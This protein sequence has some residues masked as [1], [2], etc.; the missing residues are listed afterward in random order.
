MTD[1]NKYTSTLKRNQETVQKNLD[2]LIDEFDGIP[3]GNGYIDIIILRER[4]VDFINRLTELHLAIE[5]ISWWC[6]ATDENIGKFGCPHGFGGP[7]TQFGWFS[8]M[9][10]YH[11]IDKDAI[12]HLENEYTSES[13][14]RINEMAAKMIMDNLA[15]QKRICLTPGFWIRVP[16]DWIRE[17]KE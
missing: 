11:D 1:G 14:R 2:R 8:E 9:C 10:E 5:C 13:V 4:Y 7:M 16:D 17:T 6:H 3:V 12:G 15:F